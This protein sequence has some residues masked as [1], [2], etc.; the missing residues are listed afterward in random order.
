MHKT[1]YKRKNAHY[2]IFGQKTYSNPHSVK[3]GSWL[4]VGDGFQCHATTGTTLLGC[5][6]LS[7]NIKENSKL[8]KDVITSLLDHISTI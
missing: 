7:S 2:S 3:I 5:G 6:Q 8:N 1:C 4:L